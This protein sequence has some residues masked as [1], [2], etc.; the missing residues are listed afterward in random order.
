MK[1]KFNPP[2][3]GYSFPNRFEFKGLSK[4]LK[5][6][7]SN[8]IY[9]MCGGMVFTAL[10]YYFD[11]NKLPGYMAIDELPLSYTKYLRKR[12]TQSV[13][14]SVLMKIIKF[15]TLSVSKSRKKSIQDEL[16]KIIERLNDG[17][18]TPIVIIRS[19]FFQNPTHNHQVLVTGYEDNGSTLDLELYDPNHPKIVPRL[20]ICQNS[21]YSITQSTGEPVRGFFINVY[22]YQFSL[23]EPNSN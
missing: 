19:S 18:P 8:F 16:P 4:I 12:Q 11:Q 23:E 20:T 14:I 1:T 3:H 6:I 17:L 7:K 22:S 21:E 13:S 10:D 5:L 15:A 9:G 2:S